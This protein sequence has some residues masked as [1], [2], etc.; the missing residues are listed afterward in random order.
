MKS[1]AF[2]LTAI[3]IALLGVSC[4]STNIQTTNASIQPA[5]LD[6]GSLPRDQYIIIGKVSG[7]GIIVANNRDIQR[8]AKKK[9]IEEPVFNEAQ[10]SGDNG[11]YGFLGQPNTNMT[12]LE[13][14][15]AMA[16]YKMIQAAQY[17]GADT[18]IY[19]NTTTTI[20]PKGH[21]LFSSKSTVTAKV[22]GLA[23]K[24]KPNE[25]IQVKVPASDEQV[26]KQVELEEAPPVKVDDTDILS[27]EKATNSAATTESKE[28]QQVPADAAQ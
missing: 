28:T 27:T 5:T 19:V 2:F 20:I 25:G 17:N 7:E 26:F 3:F 23:V 8:E 15:V 1:K 18:V 6:L 4:T 9:A 10:A 22:T 13:K 12:I 21:S 11:R 14:A 24:I 16:T